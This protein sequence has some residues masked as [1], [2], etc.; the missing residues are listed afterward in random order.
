MYLE[1]CTGVSPPWYG[2]F[3]RSVTRLARPFHDIFLYGVLRDVQGPAV[4]K[5]APHLS[6]DKSKEGLGELYEKEVRL[7]GSTVL[8]FAGESPIRF[9]RPASI[10]ITRCLD[11]SWVCVAACLAWKYQLYDSTVSFKLL[12]I[13]IIE[14]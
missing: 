5:E 13:D 14:S 12:H 7:C 6:Q 9:F 3:V 11:L 10:R 8:L 4:R 2:V 1:Y